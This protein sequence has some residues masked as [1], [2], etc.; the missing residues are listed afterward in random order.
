ME[1]CFY[2][3]HPH[4]LPMASRYRSC[5]I[6]QFRL[7]IIGKKHSIISRPRI[8]KLFNYSLQSVKR[9]RLLNMSVGYFL[10]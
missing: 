3:L 1:T 9:S 8:I 4:K 10:T 5:Y 2:E 7:E 6:N